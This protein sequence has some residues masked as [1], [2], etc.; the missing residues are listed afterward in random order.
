MINSLATRL[1]FLR[2]DR[3]EQFEG[4]YDEW[5]ESR[6]TYIAPAEKQEKAPKPNA[7]KLQKEQQS[8]QRKAATAVKRIEAEIEAAERET[9]EINLRLADSSRDYQEV[10]ADTERLSELELL[11]AE[12]MERWEQA[13]KELDNL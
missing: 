3:M 4:S 13:M 8:R 9:E 6:G 11:Q 7:Y 5:R 1:M 12:L 2:S 10:M